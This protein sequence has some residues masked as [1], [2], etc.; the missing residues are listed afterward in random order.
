MGLPAKLM[1]PGEREV[2]SVRTHWKSLVV[3]GVLLLAVV[4]FA[5]FC[6]ALLPDGQ[7][8]REG[9]IAVG[10]A[11]AV[12]VLRLSVWPFLR[13]VATTYTLTN[14]RLAHRSGVLRRVGRDIPLHRISDVAYERSLSDRVFGCGTLVV[15]TANEGGETLIDDIPHVGEFHLAMTSLLFEEEDL[16]A[17]RRYAGHRDE[18]PPPPRD[19]HFRRGR[20]DASPWDQDEDDA[21]RSAAD[22]PDETGEDPTAEPT[23]VQADESTRVQPYDAPHVRSR[24]AGVGPSRRRRRRP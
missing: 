17:R 13:W 15:A 18:A 4:A 1:T 23:R 20:A 19:N 7:Y 12:L 9:R 21:W 3:P 10:A 2:M 24:L 22:D 11:G 14:R 8:R 6:A 16:D 5:S